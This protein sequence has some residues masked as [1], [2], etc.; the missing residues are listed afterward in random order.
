M[1][2][3]YGCVSEEGMR[4]NNEDCLGFWQPAEQEQQRTHGALAVIADGVGGQGQGEVASRLAVEIALRGFQEAKENIPPKQILWQIIT[5]ANVAVY[6]RGMEKRDEGRMASTLTVS[7]LRNSEVTIGH[8]GDCRVYHVQGGTAHPV[9]ADHSYAA[10]QLK[11]GLISPQEAAA[12]QLRS[13]LTR[14]I[15]K[16]PTVQVD[17]YTLRVNQ[18]DYLVQCTDGLH[19]SI[20]E[21]ELAEIVTHAPPEEAC[22]QLVALARSAARTTTSRCRWCGSTAWKR[23]CFTADCPSIGKSSCP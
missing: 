12:S 16:E 10:M 5:A 17:F 6:D 23:S 13:L 14:S 19:H 8:V 1:E 21:E 15:G 18:G 2:L 22:R 20:S 7:L 3:T 4:P 9:T 11:L